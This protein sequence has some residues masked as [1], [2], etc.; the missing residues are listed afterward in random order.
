MCD[1]ITSQFLV[2]EEILKMRTPQ[3]G[4]FVI[5]EMNGKLIW[6]RPLSEGRRHLLPSSEMNTGI[7]MGYALAAPL[8]RVG[9]NIKGEKILLNNGLSLV[10]MSTGLI[11]SYLRNSMWMF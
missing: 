1:S 5:L 6:T 9:G 4:D 7:E 3:Y 11:L 2:I 8:L 10:F